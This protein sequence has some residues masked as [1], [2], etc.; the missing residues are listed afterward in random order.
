MA[1]DRAVL[2][3]SPARCVR[4][5]ETAV[6]W[7]NTEQPEPF[8][9]PKGPLAHNSRVT[10]AALD[11]PEDPDISILHRAYEP[12]ACFT[13]RKVESVANIAAIISPAALLPEWED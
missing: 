9:N 8:A 7:A 10:A 12:Q 13:W 1:T 5:N 11:L 3:A 2:S 4:S 6:S